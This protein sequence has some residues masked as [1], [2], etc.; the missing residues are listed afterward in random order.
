MAKNYYLVLGISPNAT[1]E[2]IRSAYRR[3]AKNLHPDRVG[4]GCE[5]FQAVQEAYEVLGDPASRRA[6]DDQ[7][8]R[9]Q[10]LPSAPRGI[11]PEPLRRRRCPVEPLVPEQRS[12]RL[13]VSFSDLPLRSQVGGIFGE[14]WRGLFYEA[15]SPKASPGGIHVDVH[16]TPDEALAGGRIRAVIPVS[17]RCPTCYGQGSRLLFTCPRCLGRGTLAG[18]YSVEI[19][20]PPSVADRSTLTVLL[21]QLDAG[22]AYLVLHFHV[23][24]P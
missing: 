14:P 7:L 5:P 15:R 24:G 12:T 8:A 21:T 11:A 10:H 22:E 4:G 9:E 17:T 20:Y 3:K 23:G 19:P 13:D 6:H 18:D 16:L 2:Q 1:P